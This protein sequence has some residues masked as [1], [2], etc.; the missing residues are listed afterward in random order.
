MKDSLVID[1][2]FYISLKN[3]SGLAQNKRF[4]GNLKSFIANKI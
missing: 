2:C 3:I 1:R 4:M